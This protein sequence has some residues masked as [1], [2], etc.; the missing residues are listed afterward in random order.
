MT[1]T[2]ATTVILKKAPAYRLA[3]DGTLP[4]WSAFGMAGTDALGVTA[5]QSLAEELDAMNLGEGD[6]LTVTG[7]ISLNTWEGKDGTERS[8]LKIVAS[9]AEVITPPAPKRRPRRS[10][11]PPAP[12]PLEPFYDDP[13]PDWGTP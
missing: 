13:L 6:A 12:P 10:N 4:V 5:F 2:A 9:K 1:I 7:T 3:K 11:Q 8:G